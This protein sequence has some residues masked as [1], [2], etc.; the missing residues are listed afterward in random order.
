MKSDMGA[1]VQ[2]QKQSK[3]VATVAWVMIGLTCLVALIPGVGFLT[4][5]VALPILF[6][7]VILGIVVLC[8]GGTIRGVLIL[9]MSLIVAP[10]FL[11][12]AP[13]IMTSLAVGI[14]VNANED[15]QLDSGEDSKQSEVPALI[16]K[17][18]WKQIGFNVKKEVSV[19]KQSEWDT[20]QFG[21]ADITEQD[22]KSIAPMKG[23]ENMYPRYTITRETYKSNQLAEKRLV[24][25]RDHDP[26]LDSKMQPKLVLRRGFTSGKEVW[27]VATDAVIFS[28]T[29]LDK[30]LKAIQDFKK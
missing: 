27:I 13:L 19:K 1:S 23:H 22:I 18:D 30:V 16:T 26:L 8:Q 4:W 15:F 3:G 14:G 9:L 29:E 2:Q 25:L 17:S 12:L 6:I 21:K 10:V 20:K 11:F 28:K 5:L 7:T 24:R